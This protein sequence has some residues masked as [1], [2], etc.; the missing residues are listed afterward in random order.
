MQRVLPSS[1]LFRY[2]LPVRQV[3]SAGAALPL[4]LP[5]EC[6]L[7]F[8]NALDDRAE[9]AVLKLA[10]NA[11]GLGVSVDVA[12]KR[13]PPQCDPRNPAESEGLQIW[14]DTRD[15]QTIHRASRFCHHFCILPTGTGR[16]K[17][18][19]AAIQRPIARAKEDAPLAGPASIPVVAALRTDGYRL[20]AWIPAEAM[21][22]FDPEAV[23]RLGFFYLLRDSE[24]GDQTL[25]VGEEFP[26]PHDPSVWSTLE[27]VEGLKV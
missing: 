9:F 1:F 7:P 20:D 4:N 3:E 10:W 24:L 17:R 26:Y 23:P 15:T 5:E 22:G 18:E 25:T 8:P 12:G 16:K 11:R 2:S 14:V 6:R 13:R 19:P 27:L 21:H